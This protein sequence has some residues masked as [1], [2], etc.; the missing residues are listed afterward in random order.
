[1]PEQY[2]TNDNSDPTLTA[3]PSLPKDG[4]TAHAEA[5]SGDAGLWQEAQERVLLYLKMLGIPAFYSIDIARET[6]HQARKEA[7]QGSDAPPTR[8]AMRALHNILV[9][10]GHFVKET[11]YGAYPIL[12]RRFRPRNAAAAAPEQTFS[13]TPRTTASPPLDRRP[14][15][16]KKMRRG[17]F[18]STA[19]KRLFHALGKALRFP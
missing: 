14:M 16:S 10:D 15:T 17:S 12:Y 11:P 3:P 18:F 19:L 5:D 1:M 13:H 7:R 8:L 4:P 2:A 9:N 6:L